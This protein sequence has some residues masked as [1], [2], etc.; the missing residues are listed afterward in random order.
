MYWH[1][2]VDHNKNEWITGQ[3]VESGPEDNKTHVT[4]Y[5]PDT[6]A[7]EEL[8]T[9]NPKH[10]DMELLAAIGT[11]PYDADALS[12]DD[13]LPLHLRKVAKQGEAK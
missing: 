1:V 5:Y 3:V 9:H 13:D 6:G 8:F 2:G 4:V 10:W 12:D 11:A 7:G